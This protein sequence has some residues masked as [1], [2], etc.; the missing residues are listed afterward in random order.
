VHRPDEPRRRQ[1]IRG[2]RDGVAD[3]GEDLRGVLD[4][5]GDVEPE[6]LGPEVV[7]AQL[8]RGDDAEV[9]AAARSAQCRSGCSS[10]LARTRRPSA[11]TIS[12][13]TRLS[14]VIPSRR[15]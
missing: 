7:Q 8:E 13:E 10:A 2:V 14:T 5:V 11:S 6:D 15:R 4:G 3:A 12:A 9:A 1:R